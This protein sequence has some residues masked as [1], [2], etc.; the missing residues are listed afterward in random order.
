M[1]LM[2]GKPEEHTCHLFKKENLIPVVLSFYVLP[3]H[4]YLLN[5]VFRYSLFVVVF[6]LIVVYCTGFLFTLVFCFG[7]EVV[8]DRCSAQ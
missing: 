7:Q 4:L 3:L 6:C 2:F 8:S 5:W 1:F